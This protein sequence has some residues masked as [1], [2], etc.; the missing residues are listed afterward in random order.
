MAPVVAA[1]PYIAAAVTAGSA[2]YTAVDQHQQGKENIKNAREANEQAM[3][4]A[5]NKANALK[6]ANAKR[7]N[8]FDDTEQASQKSLLTAQKAKRRAVNG[9]AGTRLTGGKL[10]SPATAGGATLLGQS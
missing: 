1:I 2:V 9:A 3:K 10:G 4:D 6:E 5:K 7:S 8:M